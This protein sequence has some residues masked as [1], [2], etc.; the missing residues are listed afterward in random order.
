MCL[1]SH[2]LFST[3]LLFINNNLFDSYLKMTYHFLLT[4]S[5]AY[6]KD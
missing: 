1:N 6:F 5:K 2:N 3:I 4:Y